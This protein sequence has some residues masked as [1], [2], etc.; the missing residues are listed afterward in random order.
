MKTAGAIILSFFFAASHAQTA[1]PDKGVSINAGVK[2]LEMTRKN[3]PSVE[4]KFIR[5]NYS[6]IASPYIS[7]A[8]GRNLYEEPGGFE[9]GSEALSIKAGSLFRLPFTDN[10][11]DRVFLRAGVGYIMRNEK[12]SIVVEN[13]H[14]GNRI[15]DYR[16]SSHSWFMELGLRPE[17]GISDRFTFN[18]DVSGYI[19]GNNM[20]QKP[21]ANQIT[22]REKIDFY[23]PN[24][25][26]GLGVNYGFNFTAGF[27]FK[28]R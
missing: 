19:I 3:P 14:W 18:L 11:K 5:F 22:Y 12:L 24:P 25:G 13:Q 8:A 21:F 26:L 15:M 7:L 2:L 6:K 23:L 17:F 16:Q 27:G 9:T 10:G 4:L 1:P 20:Q 28:I